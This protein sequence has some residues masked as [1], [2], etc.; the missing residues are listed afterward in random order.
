MM[1]SS[2]LN[3]YMESLLAQ[4]SISFVVVDNAK[5][6]TTNEKPK[7][8]E[9]AFCLSDDKPLTPPRKNKTS[10]GFLRSDKSLAAMMASPRPVG[11]KQSKKGGLDLSDHSRGETRWQTKTSNSNDS[12]LSTPSR[13]SRKPTYQTSCLI[14]APRSSSASVALSTAGFSS[15]DGRY[16]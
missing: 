6:A 11:R 7:R 5:V 4:R 15:F 14:P 9:C 16:R 13:S 1:P 2:A 12:L 8:M 10:A 3:S